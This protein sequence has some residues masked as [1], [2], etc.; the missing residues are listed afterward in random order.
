MKEVDAGAYFI[1]TQMFYDVDTF[2][3][4]VSDCRKW[5]INV[6]IIPKILPVQNCNGF[7]KISGFCMTKVPTAVSKAIEPSKDDNEAV[8]ESGA[9]LGVDMCQ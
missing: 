1:I 4:F 3:K 8:K 5:D 7:K 9:R 6:P 2:L